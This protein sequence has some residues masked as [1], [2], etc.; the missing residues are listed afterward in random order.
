MNTKLLG[1]ACLFSLAVRSQPPD[2]SEIRLVG[3]S[4]RGLRTIR[5]NKGKAKIVDEFVANEVGAAIGG[6]AG[7]AAYDWEKGVLF[8]VAPPFGDPKWVHW[9]D[10]REPD[11]Q[12]RTLIPV[13]PNQLAVDPFLVR[14]GPDEKLFLMQYVEVPIKMD[15]SSPRVLRPILR[16]DTNGASAID[17]LK[18]TRPLS[19]LSKLITFG[20]PGGYGGTMNDLM[21]DGPIRGGKFIGPL[22]LP[23]EA[24]TLAF[25]D[26]KGTHFI[27]D[28][29]DSRSIMLAVA[30]EGRIIYDTRTKKRAQPRGIDGIHARPIRS[31]G[32]WLGAALHDYVEFDKGP[33]PDDSMEAIQ[34]YMGM[35]AK[36]QLWLYEVATGIETIF[37]VS[38]RDSEVLLVTP[39]GRV[40][41]RENDRVYGAKIVGPVI[42]QKTLLCQDPW[43]PFVHWAIEGQAAKTN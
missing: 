25:P 28:L 9:I 12:M 5:P 18:E 14:S 22:A 7:Y 4:A 30:G 37:P 39:D 17:P 1:L 43:I 27:V 40:V 3:V 16:I 32:N 2:F 34:K 24:P 19:T 41:F 31:Y 13:L 15:G 6:S 23:L 10:R 20:D 26:P 42:Q 8:M 35:K 38:H 21:I 29:I 36:K 33:E 11:R